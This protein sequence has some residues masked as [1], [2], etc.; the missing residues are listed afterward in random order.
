MNNNKNK[1]YI[2]FL[3]LNNFMNEEITVIDITDNIYKEL[4]RYTDCGD[5]SIDPKYFRKWKHIEIK[6]IYKHNL[7]CSSIKKTIKE[8]FKKYKL[9]VEN[10]EYYIINNYNEY[11][12]QER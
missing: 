1:N 5:L 12:N 9:Y 11:K 2:Y 8:S 6:Y 10:K 3:N 4:M 7:D